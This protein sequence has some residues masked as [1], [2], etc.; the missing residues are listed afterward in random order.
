MPPIDAQKAANGRDMNVWVVMAPAFDEGGWIFQGVFS[1]ESRANEF[2][3]TV[4][5]RVY[6]YPRIVD[7]V[8]TWDE[9]CARPAGEGVIPY[10]A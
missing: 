5:H 2:A 6:V 8:V 4:P 1:S 7:G 3:A 9:A 10:A